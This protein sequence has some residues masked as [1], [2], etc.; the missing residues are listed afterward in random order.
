[1]NK[2]GETT[3]TTIENR[4]NSLWTWNNKQWNLLFENAKLNENERNFV[5]AWMLDITL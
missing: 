3:I 2:I 5:L 1:M 4:W